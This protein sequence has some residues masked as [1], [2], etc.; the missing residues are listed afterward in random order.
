ML[1]KK[2]RTRVVS[3]MKHYEGIYTL[4]FETL[5][6]RF[7]Y[8]PGQFLHLALDSDYDGS[9]QWPESRCFSMQ[10]N[11]DEFSIRITY[12][13]KG[14][15][16]LKMEQLLNVGSEV[17]LKLPYGNL[18]TQHHKKKNAV[19]IAG[20][21]GITPFISLFTHDSFKEYENPRVYLGFKTKAYNIYDND[22]VNVKS[23]TPKIFYED[24]EGILDI[25]SILEENGRDNDYFISGPPKM[26]KVFKQVLISKD[27]PKSHILVDEWE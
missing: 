18:F 27:V 3:I 16:T 26:I 23:C 1:V 19:F 6:G 5:N 17:W 2:Y 14:S 20:G 15:F 8:Y 9:G 10:S 11:P 7:K 12:S 22:M 24:N 13:I 25:N 21:T 4:E